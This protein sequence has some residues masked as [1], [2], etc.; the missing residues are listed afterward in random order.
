MAMG[1]I[2][3]GRRAACEAVEP[4]RRD[5]LPWAPGPMAYAA[6]LGAVS[7]YA[8][9]AVLAGLVLA[10]LVAGLVGALLVLE[11]GSCASAPVELDGRLVAGGGR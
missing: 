6:A 5:P 11:L 1:A 4:V 7:A 10:G 3:R 2:P 9:R 8:R